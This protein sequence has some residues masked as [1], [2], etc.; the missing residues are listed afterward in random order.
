MNPPSRF[1]SDIPAELLE[2]ISIEPPEKETIYAI[3]SKNIRKQDEEFSN[4]YREIE[5]KGWKSG[6]KVRHAKFGIG[7]VVGVEEG[8]NHLKLRIAFPNWGLK[9]LLADYV[10]RI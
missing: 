8:K 3:P 6:V 7:M 5:I 10:Q 9:T 4:A 1:L 2:K